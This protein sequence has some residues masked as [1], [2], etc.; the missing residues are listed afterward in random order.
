MLLCFHFKDVVQL[1]AICFSNSATH[2]T[3]TDRCLK[4][5]AFCLKERDLG[6]FLFFFNER[7]CGF[8]KGSLFFNN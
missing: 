5:L 4:V 3:Q 7:S 6:F 8:D 1:N 2:L